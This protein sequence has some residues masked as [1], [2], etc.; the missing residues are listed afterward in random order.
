MFERLT[1]SRRGERGATL[2]EYALV[3]ALVAI[4]SIGAVEV[5]TDESES[6]IQ[7]QADCVSQRPPPPECLIRAITTTTTLVPP[8]IT[9]TTVPPPA[10]PAPVLSID[11]PARKST[12]PAPRWVEVDVQLE[13]EQAPDLGGGYVPVPGTTVRAT[14]LLANPSDPATYFPEEWFRDCTTNASGQCTIR[15]D[16]PYN[17]IPSIRFEVTGADT[18]PAATLSGPMVLT[19]S[20]P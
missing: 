14:I 16:L 9:V 7:N 17:D 13:I 11:P 15:F 1:R 2:V 12:D 18:T 20:W 8:S 5:L 19:P 6:E 10:P 4:V 3:F